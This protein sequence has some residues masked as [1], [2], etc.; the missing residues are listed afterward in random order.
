MNIL[1][2]KT[3]LEARR[4][5]LEKRLTLID[6]DLSRELDDDSGDRAIETENDEVLIGLEQSGREELK[7]IHSALDRIEKG[8]FGRCVLCGGDIGELRLKALPFTPYCIE[9]SR[10]T[11]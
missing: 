11:A 7:A 10:E 4:L 5:E 9:C 6:T 1:E 3:E 2:I 8:D